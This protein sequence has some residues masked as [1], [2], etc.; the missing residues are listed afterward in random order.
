MNHKMIAANFQ[1]KCPNEVDPFNT[2][3][4]MMQIQK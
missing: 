3:K 2:M 4:K 1:V